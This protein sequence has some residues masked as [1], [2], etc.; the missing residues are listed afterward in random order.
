MLIVHTHP[1]NLEKLKKAT[2][3]EQVCYGEPCTISPLNNLEVRTSE[4]IQEH[5]IK[6]H[7]PKA[8]RFYEYEESDMEWLIY[9][10]WTDKEYKPIF[11]LQRT[12]YMGTVYPKIKSYKPYS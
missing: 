9:C 4:L 3:D 11:Y 2:K 1:N 10:G 7:L 6:H 12:D 5:D 8:E